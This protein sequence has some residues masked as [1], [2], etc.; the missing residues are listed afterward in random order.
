MAMHKLFV[1]DFDD[2]PYSLVAIHC[3]LEDY[4]LAYLL[5]Q[6]L[7]IRLKRNQHD[8]DFNYIKASYAIFEW[9]DEQRQMTWNLVANICKREEDA[10]VSSGSLFELPMKNIASFNLIPEMGQVDYFLKIQNDGKPINEKTILSKIHAIPQVAAAYSVDSYELKS[11]EN[12]IF[13]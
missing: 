11:R 8:V 2:D 10:L 7:K 3:S 9:D 5:N 12:L 4:R 1:D 13:N 6:A